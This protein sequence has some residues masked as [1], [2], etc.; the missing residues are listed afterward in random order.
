MCKGGGDLKFDRASRGERWGVASDE[1]LV[2]AV[3]QPNTIW[4][5]VRNDQEV[6]DAPAK[7]PG[8]PAHSMKQC[9]V[10]MFGAKILESKAAELLP[11]KEANI[12]VFCAG[13][14]RAE[15]A[16]NALVK[17]GYTGSITNG[18]M[19]EDILPIL[20]ELVTNK[21]GGGGKCC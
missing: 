7:F 2:A 19:P 14:G 12:I 21:D 9:K 16:K 20:P 13:G 17:M 5:D 6:A 10:T 1:E 8:V 15:V 11:D 4:L 3:K 18:G